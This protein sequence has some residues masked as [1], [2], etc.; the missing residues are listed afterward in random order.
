M[1]TKLASNE[2]RVIDSVRK[3][4]KKLFI[5]SETTGITKEA[6]IK[7]LARHG[8]TAEETFNGKEIG[9][10]SPFFMLLKEENG[11]VVYRRRFDD[12]LEEND[13]M[14]ISW[15]LETKTGLDKVWFRLTGK[16]FGNKH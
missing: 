7:K 13:T 4:D 2:T 10:I 5:E 6:K 14:T 1:Y 3:N 15:I 16:I 9:N 12:K 8:I 11:D